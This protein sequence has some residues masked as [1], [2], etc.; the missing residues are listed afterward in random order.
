MQEFYI[1]VSNLYSPSQSLVKG[2]WFKLI[3]GAS[4]QD[5]PDVRNLVLAYTLAGA[6]CVDVAADP[7]VVA[8]ATEAIEIAKTLKDEAV[9]KG[10]GMQGIP[11]LMVSLNDGLDPHFRKAQFDVTKCPTD[12]SRPCL[13]VCPAGA[14]QF[15][16]RQ[17]TDSNFV[18]LK[19]NV[20]GVIDRRCY[21]CGRCLPICPSQLIFSRS[22]VSATT[23]IAPLVQELGIDAIEIHTHVGHEEDFQRLWNA[24]APWSDRLKLLAI[25]CPDGEGYVDYLRTLYEIIRPLPCHLIWQTDGRPMSGDIGTGT[26]HAAIKLAQKALAANLPGSI[27]LAG[28][29]NNHT[30]VKLKAVGLL[31]AENI[32]I[33]NNRKHLKNVSGVAYGGYA[34]SLLLPFLQELSESDSKNEV[35]FF[36][37]SINNNREKRCL[38]SNPRILWQAV[39]KASKI[40]SQI[41]SFNCQTT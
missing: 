37:N 39:A 35:R 33:S 40:V 12:C 24:I 17:A 21:G 9:E 26:T 13:S 41:K 23:T 20:N 25:S 11:W 30:V 4:F 31:K 10:F 14:I 16:D 18:S 5:L 38:E 32:R 3:C 2:N 7:A 36:G 27:Q 15:K 19:E 22:Y 29:T 6:D 8:A 1:A 34:R 28:G